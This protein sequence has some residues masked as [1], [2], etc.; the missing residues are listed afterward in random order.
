MSTVTTSRPIDPEKAPAQFLRDPFI[1]ALAISRRRAEEA[2]PAAENKID[3]QDPGILP[4]E[5]PAT[6]GATTRLDGR[7][8]KNE[9]SEKRN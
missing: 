6:S 7:G 2:T 5:L 8:Q 4:L 3:Q 9:N 1:E